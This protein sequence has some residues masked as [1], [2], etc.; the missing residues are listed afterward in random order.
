M[1][2][3]NVVLSFY[4]ILQSKRIDGFVIR[5]AENFVIEFQLGV[6]IN[7]AQQIPPLLLLA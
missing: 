6:G 2:D 3:R 5:P 7:L 4:K 1:F